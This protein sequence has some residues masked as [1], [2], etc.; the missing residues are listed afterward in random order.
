MEY[1]AIR[2]SPVKSVEPS[3]NITGTTQPLLLSKKYRKMDVAEKINVPGD[4]RQLDF[5]KPQL[6]A[7]IQGPSQPRVLMDR[8]GK[9]VTG[10]LNTDVHVPV[11]R[12]DQIIPKLT[13]ENRPRVVKKDQVV[14]KIA[15]RGWGQTQKLF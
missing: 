4:N 9:E 10:K 5:K 14:G 2:K 8:A 12:K 3:P 1:H 7:N 6:P 15:A 13:G 11:V